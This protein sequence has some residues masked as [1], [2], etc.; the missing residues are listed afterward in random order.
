M[1]K[2][3]R[4]APGVYEITKDGKMY[5][6]IYKNRWSGWTLATFS[7]THKQFIDSRYFETLKAAKTAIL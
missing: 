6:R 7:E 2:I 5:Y 3:F 1:K 4:L